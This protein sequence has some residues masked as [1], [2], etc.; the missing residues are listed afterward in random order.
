DQAEKGLD[1]NAAVDIVGNTLLIL[2]AKKIGAARGYNSS[3][4]PGRF[5]TVLLRSGADPNAADNNR[6][7]PLMAACGTRGRDGED[8][9]LV[10]LEKGAGVSATDDK[11]RTPL[12]YAAGN[13]NTISGR[14]M[15]E[16]LFEFGDPLPA[17]VGNDRKSA[18]DIA[19]EANNEELVKYLLTKL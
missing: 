14:N 9:Q 16:M 15:A 10:L 18:L 6:V 8:A 4:L 2:A 7:T 3:T 13:G 5:L 1:L 17:A 12:M 11:G 19:V